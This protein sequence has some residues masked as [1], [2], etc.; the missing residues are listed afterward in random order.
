MPVSAIVT[1]CE[2]DMNSEDSENDNNW[3]NPTGMGHEETGDYTW[4]A[5]SVI[6]IKL[7]GTTITSTSAEVVI[8]G[9]NAVINKQGNYQVSGILSD[10]MLVIDVDEDEMVRII[11]N[12]VSIHN[13]TGPA[14]L[15]EKSRKTIINLEGDSQNF[16]SD[17]TEY[18]N[19]GDDPNAA[20]FSKSDLTIFG[21]G[22]LSVEGNYKDGITGKDGLIVKSGNIVVSS[23]DDGIRGKD[24]LI[25]D[26]PNIAINS[27]GDGLKSDNE[28][29]NTTGQVLIYGGVINAITGGDGISAGNT[30]ISTGGYAHILSGG[31]NTADTISISQKGIKAGQSVKLRMDSLWIDAADHAVDSD[32]TIEISGGTYTLFS[33]RAG[34]HSNVSSTVNGGEINIIRSMEGFESKSILINGGSIKISSIDDC[35]NATAGYDV[36]V[37]DGSYIG[38]SDGYLVLDCLR[39]DGVDSNG[40]IELKGGRIIIHG[41][42]SAPEVA[43]DFNKSFNISGGFLVGSGTNSELIE[44]PDTTSTQNSLMAVFAEQY[45]ELTIFHIEDDEGNP[46][47]T[48]Q[49]TGQFQSILFTSSEFQTGE[50]YYLDIGGSSTGSSVDGIIEG[51]TY[52]PGSRLSSFTIS[53]RVTILNNLKSTPKIQ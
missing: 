30:I 53:S 6:E 2:K 27:G 10:G 4:D 9:S 36:D 26:S 35:L 38:I 24:Y 39:G 17:A 16:L 25:V 3:G 32:G 37:D 43:L 5:S 45:P 11:L 28:D 22:S 44:Y 51:G 12:N 50:T 33:A 13:S 34:V 20:L 18:S 23:E 7:N 21:T 42:P 41:P 48:F 19:P 1:S 29:S 46:I 52:T 14:I 49:P 40:S 47:L 8:N 15:V 31:G